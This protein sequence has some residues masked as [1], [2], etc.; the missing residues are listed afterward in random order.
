LNFAK[1]IY[2]EIDISEFVITQ[3]PFQFYRKSFTEKNSIQLYSDQN[4]LYL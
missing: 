1:S 3:I 2:I 4:D